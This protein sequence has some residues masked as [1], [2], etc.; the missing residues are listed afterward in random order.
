MTG[1]GILDLPDVEPGV[2]PAD[3]GVEPPEVVVELGRAVLDGLS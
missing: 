3:P 2:E 1:R